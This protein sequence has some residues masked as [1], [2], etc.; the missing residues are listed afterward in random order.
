MRTEAYVVLLNTELSESLKH[1]IIFIA[2]LKHK[3]TLLIFSVFE[4]NGPIQI[5]SE[6]YLFIVSELYW[7]CVYFN[8]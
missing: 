3:N 6:N 1:V 4:V 2:I 5:F 8:A 7:S